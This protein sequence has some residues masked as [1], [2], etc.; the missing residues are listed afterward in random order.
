MS[1]NHLSGTPLTDEAM[2]RELLWREGKVAFDDTPLSGAFASFERYGG[3]T[4]EVEDRQLLSRTVSGVFSSDDPMGFA[5]VVAQLFDL[6]ASSEG[7]KISLR[8]KR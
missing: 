1:G 3:V 7:G 4:F 6:E 2:A 5:K 8:N